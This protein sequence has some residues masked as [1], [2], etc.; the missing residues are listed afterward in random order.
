MIAYLAPWV[1]DSE[2]PC[3]RSPAGASGAVDLRTIAQA[4]TPESPEGYGIFAY[5]ADPGLSE[6]IL[7]GDLAKEIDAGALS[8]L[9]DLLK[10]SGVKPGSVSDV[11]WQLFTG[12]SDPSGETAPKP[13]RTVYGYPIEL[14]LG[15]ERRQDGVSA[16]DTQRA[17]EVFQA[18]YVAAKSSGVSQA[19]LQ[20]WTGHAMKDVYGQTGDDLAIAL[21]PDG[22]K[23]DG[24]VPPKTVVYDD[25]NRANG[26]LGGNW[27]TDTG[28]T[29]IASNQWTVTAGE[30]VSRY[31]GQSLS[32]EN[33]YGQAT[34]TARGGGYSGPIARKIAS[35][36]LT[37][38]LCAVQAT[39]N[40]TI[41]L[42]KRVT[43]TY[44]SLGTFGVNTVAGDVLKVL[45]RG[46]TIQCYRNNVQIISVTDT[47]ITGNLQAGIVAQLTTASYDDFLGSDEFAAATMFFSGS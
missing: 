11:L 45:C 44:T 21:L 2:T 46:S 18:D 9:E 23:D 34:I 28:T 17:I 39:G 15:A 37:Y 3:W 8:K 1:W 14:Y 36:T 25:F 20:K 22:F 24:W 42:Y 41:E 12:L 7:L 30:A 19:D 6:G 13:L 26:G 47:S 16:E 35:S 29:A 31:S 43:G 32:S 40:D 5:E 38:Y 33:H 27:T 4:G 10:I